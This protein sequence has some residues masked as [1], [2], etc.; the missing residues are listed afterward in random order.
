MPESDSVLPNSSI[1]NSALPNSS[2]SNSSVANTFQSAQWVFA[3]H[4]RDPIENPA[5]KDIEDRRMAVYRDLIYNNIESFLSGGFPVL[6]SLF[7]DSD[8]RAL[9]RTFLK[10]YRCHTPYFLEISQEFLN[11]LREGE[12][13]QSDDKPFLIEL[14]HYE[15][16][17]LA[18]DVSP[19]ILPEIV[20]CTERSLLDST[21]TI[22]PLTWRLSYQYPVH[23]I[24]RD[25]QPQEA[26]TEATSLLVYRDSNDEVH[27]MESNNVTMR[28][29]QLL[30]T[31]SMS[32]REA[33][34]QIALELQYPDPE[35]LVELGRHILQQLVKASVLF[36][37]Q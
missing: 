8:W 14:A 5:P 17:E 32:G 3:A 30:E 18:L 22:S 11:F 35:A 4:M 16:V 21:Y 34:E 28:L 7:T 6:R 29:L 23:K 13:Y 10:C 25:Y 9:V 19:E 15:W 12:F 2:V 36:Y 24:S 33:L 1:S 26:P 37:H 20:A 31:Q 27:F